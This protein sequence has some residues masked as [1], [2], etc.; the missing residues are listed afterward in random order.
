MARRLAERVGTLPGVRITQDVRANAVFAIL[1]RG[2]AERLQRAWAFYTWDEATGEVRWMCS[3][4][5]TPEDVDAFAA[6]VEEV[7][8][9]PV[10]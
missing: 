2:A 6:A 4:D 5:T 9:S 1:P 8:G 10:R 3:W 7:V